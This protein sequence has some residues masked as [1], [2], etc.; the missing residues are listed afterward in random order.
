MTAIW[1]VST[2][3]AVA[4]SRQVRAAIRAV[5]AFAI[6]FTVVLSVAGAAVTVLTAAFLLAAPPV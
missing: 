1:V 3:L 4:R 5:V 2:T 6:D